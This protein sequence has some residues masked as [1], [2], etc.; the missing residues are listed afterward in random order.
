MYDI[1]EKRPSHLNRCGGL[2]Y[3][4]I[5]PGL[6]CKRYVKKGALIIVSGSIDA[7]PYIAKVDSQARAGLQLKAVDIF[8]DSSPRTE[9]AA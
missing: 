2:F 5:R 8:L 7:S 1:F 9:A 4:F 3:A 6:A